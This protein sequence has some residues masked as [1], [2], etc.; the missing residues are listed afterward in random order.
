VGTDG[1]TVRRVDVQAHS[2]SGTSVFGDYQ[3][4]AG[5]GITLDSNARIHAGTATNGDIVMNANAKQ[6]GQ[7]SVGVGHQMR[8]ASS[9]SY[10]SD[11][12]CTNPATVVGEGP[13]VLPPVNQGDAAT[14]NDN[15]RL[16]VATVTPADTISG[17]ASKV[18][19]NGHDGSGSSSSSCGTRHLDL[20]QNTALT[21]GGSK[22][23]FCKLT[24]SSNT[25]LFISAGHSAVI[26]FDSPEH[27]GYPDNTTQLTMASN[28]RISSND[29][30]PVQLMFV[31]SQNLHTSILMNSNTDINAACVQN[32]VVYA[33]LSD[34]TMNSNST[35]CGGLAAKSLHLDSNAD[36]R[37]NAAS[38]GFIV[39]PTA[40]H[41]TV[42]RFVECSAN[43]ATP[44]NSGC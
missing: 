14:N 32:F 8:T 3:V 2:V 17:N 31:G 19:W 9:N 25:S 28:T 16:P 15:G 39:P 38:Q 26:Y 13:V 12:N 10:F 37:T 1:N 24:M 27:C 22:Y 20:Q 36:I 21:L 35:Y 44:A 42:D 23:S 11:A 18:C 33:P 6:C 29:G 41:F 34:I 7:A 4:K 40:A 30:S 5:D 43:T